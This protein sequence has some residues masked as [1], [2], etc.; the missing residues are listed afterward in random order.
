LYFQWCRGLEACISADRLL[1][2]SHRRRQP[3][4]AA[5][6][7]RTLDPVAQIRLFGK[8]KLLNCANFTRVVN[9]FGFLFV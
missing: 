2:G 4:P 1:D 6:P 5:A 3:E 8:L 7:I 9:R